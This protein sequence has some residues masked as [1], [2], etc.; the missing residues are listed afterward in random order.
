M[1]INNNL[2]NIFQAKKIETAQYICNTLFNKTKNYN[3]TILKKY[4]I[5]NNRTFYI[6]IFK[7]F[8]LVKI[9]K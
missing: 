6:H 1:L 5:D 7:N 3:K 2:P 9:F 8:T 4:I